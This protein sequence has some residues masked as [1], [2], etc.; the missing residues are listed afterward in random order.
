[1]PS[2]NRFEWADNLSWVK[3]THTFKFGFDIARTEDF[4]N[5]L[6]N[7]AGTFTY[8]NVTTFAQD[9]TNPAPGPSH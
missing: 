4:S 2:E 9:F 7:R 3:G 1:M 5:S 8:A 6:S